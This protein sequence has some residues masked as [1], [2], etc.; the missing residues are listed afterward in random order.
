MI[1]LIPDHCPSIYLVKFRLYFA[2]I[3]MIK[4]IIIITIII[5][6]IDVAVVVIL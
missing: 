1:V 3:I 6:I 5:I 4:T 2:L